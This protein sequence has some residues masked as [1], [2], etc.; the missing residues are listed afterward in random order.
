MDGRSS[1][2]LLLVAVSRQKLGTGSDPTSC[3]NHGREHKHKYIDKD[4]ISND[5]NLC[6]LTS[7]Q[8]LCFQSAWLIADT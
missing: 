2:L 3:S 6:K 7:W 8:E 4:V 1:A 5:M